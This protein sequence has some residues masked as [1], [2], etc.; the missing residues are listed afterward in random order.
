MNFTNSPYF[1]GLF[2][3]G[4]W[5]PRPPRY[6]STT[7]PCDMEST[8]MMGSSGCFFS[9]SMRS[10]RTWRGTAKNEQNQLAIFPECV[11]A[12]QGFPFHSGGL[13]VEG[14]FAR[15]CF[16]VRNPSQP[17][18]TVRNRPQPS[19]TV[20]NRSRDP[21]MAVPMGSSAEVVLFGGF[22]RVVASFRV[23]G[24]ALRDIQTCSGTCRKSFCLA[25]AILC[26]VFRRCF[27]VFVAGA[28]LWTCPS[29]Y[30]VAGAAL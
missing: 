16:R 25:G 28:A 15:R 8:M 26:Y 2:S 12:T 14:V 30:F 20:R 4:Q 23:A 18:A 5:S 19:A 22:R 1:F 11:A 3:Q 21:R 10:R 7:L 6:T 27:A 24:V 29:S 9:S 13:G 17:F